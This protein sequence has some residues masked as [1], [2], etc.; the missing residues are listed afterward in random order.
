MMSMACCSNR[1][2]RSAALCIEECWPTSDTPARFSTRFTFSHH[3][4]P[5]PSPFQRASFLP[6]SSSDKVLAQ[7]IDFSVST[8]RL[9]RHQRPD[10]LGFTHRDRSYVARGRCYQSQKCVPAKANSTTSFSDIPRYFVRHELEL[11]PAERQ[12]R[13]L[14]L[15]LTNIGPSRTMLSVQFMLKR[16]HAR[17]KRVEAEGRTKVVTKLFCWLGFSTKLDGSCCQ[18]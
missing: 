17:E 8:V 15:F 16:P 4:N 5:L 3:R 10:S 18:R 6:A 13:S 11:F 14:L 2:Y 9:G 12:T 1:R 7:N